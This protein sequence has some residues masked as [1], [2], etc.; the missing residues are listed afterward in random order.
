MV[1]PGIVAVGTQHFRDFARDGPVLPQQVLAGR[2][3]LRQQRGFL[4]YEVY[5]AAD[6]IAATRKCCPVGAC[7]PVGRKGVAVRGQKQGIGAQRCRDIHRKPARTR[8]ASLARMPFALQKQPGPR[9]ALQNIL[10]GARRRVAAPIGEDNDTVAFVQRRIQS[11]KRST[12]QTFL[13]AGRH[14]GAKAHLP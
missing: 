11:Q 12:D 10:R 3:G 4:G 8:S 7:Q 2:V 14:A 13:V 6:K 5:G 9:P 1:R